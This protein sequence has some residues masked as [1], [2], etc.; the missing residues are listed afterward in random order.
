MPLSLFRFVCSKRDCPA[1]LSSPTRGRRAT[2]TP[3]LLL[4]VREGGDVGE[5]VLDVSV[6]IGVDLLGGR[7]EGQALP[8]PAAV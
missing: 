6:C 1:L 8:T 4:Q 7:G 3:L 5:V 2:L